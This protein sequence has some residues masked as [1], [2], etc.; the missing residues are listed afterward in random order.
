MLAKLTKERPKNRAAR[1]SIDKGLFPVIMPVGHSTQASWHRI[2]LMAGG[3]AGVLLPVGVVA[4]TGS[5]LSLPNAN[6][7][8]QQI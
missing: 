5:V 2:T 8:P 7:A 6:Q 3:A 1:Q 4:G